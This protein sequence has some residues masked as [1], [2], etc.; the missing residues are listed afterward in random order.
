MRRT[1]LTNNFILGDYNTSISREDFERGFR[2]TKEK[3]RFTF[4]GWDGKSYHG[5][6]RNATVYRT[7]IKGCE[8]NRYI[9]VGKAIHMILEDDLV[10]D[11]ATGEFNP[12]TMWVIDVRKAEC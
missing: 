3:V 9:K 7:D 8:N 4:N 10:E 5:E 2:K 1:Q 12:T 11:Q 6:S